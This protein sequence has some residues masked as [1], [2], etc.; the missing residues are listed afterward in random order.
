MK[1]TICQMQLKTFLGH[2]AND[3]NEPKLFRYKEECEDTCI[4]SPTEETGTAQPP[5]TDDGVTYATPGSE[6]TNDIETPISSSS[7]SESPNL[8]ECQ[9]QRGGRV[10]HVAGGFVAECEADGSFRPLQCERDGRACF[11]VN[12]AGIEVPGT[13]V[14]IPEQSKPDCSCMFGLEWR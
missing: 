9:R 5:A 13:R 12:A 2:C 4:G 6:T 1:V 11:C 8:S 7:S 10:G 14:T 3:D